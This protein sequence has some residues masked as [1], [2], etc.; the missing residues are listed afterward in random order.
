[1]LGTSSTIWLLFALFVATG[2]L[3]PPSAA[4]PA[5]AT[6]R[7]PEEARSGSA[8]MVK[9]R[10]TQPHILQHDPPSRGAMSR[11]GAHRE[12]PLNGTNV[13]LGIQ[14]NYSCLKSRE[15]CRAER[16]VPTKTLP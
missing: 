8:D 6:G 10:H 11:V 13:F 9:T 2:A 14:G 12:L 3:R 5:S 7:A 4:A 1:M 16:G 15:S